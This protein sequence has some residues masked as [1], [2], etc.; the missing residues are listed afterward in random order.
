MAEALER[1]RSVQGE[2]DLRELIVLGA[3]AALERAGQGEREREA[4]EQAKRE[5]VEWIERGPAPDLEAATEVRR[6]GFS[7]PL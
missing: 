5:L 4:R 6:H 2:A 1:V 7:R 3:E